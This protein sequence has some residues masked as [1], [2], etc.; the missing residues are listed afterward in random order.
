MQGEQPERFYFNTDGLPERDRFPAFCEGMFRT[1]IRA[2]IE[3][4]GSKPFGGALDIRQTGPV[5]IADISITAANVTRHASYI[6]DGNDAIVAQFWRRGSAFMVQGNHESRVAAGESLTIDNAKAAKFRAEDG[7]CFWAL[8]IPRD[9]IASVSAEAARVFGAK[10]TN[11]AALRLIFGYLREIKLRALVDA[12]TAQT[13][14][15]HIVDL[16][17]LALGGESTAVAEAEGVRAARQSAILQEIA[18]NSSS[19]TL[20]ARRI[21]ANLGITPRYVHMLLE[22]TGLS[23]GKH[24]LTTRLEMAEALLRDPRCRS[25]KIADIAADAGFADLSYFNRT[26][27][28]HFGA[29]PSDIREAG[30]RDT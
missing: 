7:A 24:L 16:V 3:K 10:V 14:G 23:F 29:T 18:R 27:R 4:R 9:R 28:R 30:R 5:G 17:V 6:S 8:T 1:V 20:S 15:N 26:F 12:S 11:M 21:A 2:D 19:P 25:R 22:A 13:Y